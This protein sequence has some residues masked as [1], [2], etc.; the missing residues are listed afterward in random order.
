MM[1][2]YQEIILDHYKYPRNKGKLDDPDIEFRDYN[3]LCGDEVVIQAKLG[4]DKVIEDVKFD[5]RG[6][7]ISQAAASM[8]TES[9][10]G[11]KIGEAKSITNDEMLGML[12]IP[13]S[14]MRIRCALLA[15]KALQKGIFVYEGKAA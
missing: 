4:K 5:G 7:A 15:L 12:V 2:M 3:P 14:H 10:K 8:L 13:I 6:C 1:D 9:V 11:K